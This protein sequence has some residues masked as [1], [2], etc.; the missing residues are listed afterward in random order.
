MK[1][2]LLVF[3]IIL[4]CGGYILTA[5]EHEDFYRQSIFIYP[6]EMS[7]FYPQNNVN[8]LVIEAP[9]EIV[10][11]FNDQGIDLKYLDKDCTE[12][13]DYIRQQMNQICSDCQKD[14]CCALMTATRPYMKTHYNAIV[15][16]IGD[17]YWTVWT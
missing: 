1:K 4:I 6:P 8:S 17:A 15:V 3:L 14:L 13:P 11:F 12:L 7:S 16:R 2:T 10:Q 9:D 5:R